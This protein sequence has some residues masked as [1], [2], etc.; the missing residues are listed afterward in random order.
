M[1]LHSK[2]LVL[3]VLLC[4]TLFT[5]PVRGQD[6]VKTVIATP[7][8]VSQTPINPEKQ[9]SIVLKGADSTVQ[10]IAKE[11]ITAPKHSSWFGL[12]LPV[13][14]GPLI[15]SILSSLGAAQFNLK[16][17][18]GATPLGGVLGAVAN[19]IT[20]FQKNIPPDKPDSK[21]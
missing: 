5:P 18:P 21:T 20:I 8:M 17:T 7:I 14:L 13:W 16:R 4:S 9:D 12:K 11:D 1:K 19:V 3:A 10:T 2:V 6:T 15:L